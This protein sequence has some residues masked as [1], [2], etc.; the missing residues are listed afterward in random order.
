M[1]QEKLKLEEPPTP[2]KRKRGLK[3]G[4]HK[5]Q[6]NIINWDGANG[7]LVVGQITSVR[8]NYTLGV[9]LLSK[10]EFKRQTE[11]LMDRTTR[12]SRQDAQRI[13]DVYEQEPD[14][15]K[16]RPAARAVANEIAQQLRANKG[17]GRKGKKK[18]TAPTQ[19]VL[20]PDDKSVIR[21][22]H[23][24]SVENKRR[25]LSALFKDYSSLF[26]IE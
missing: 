22:Y 5:D 8:W 7:D 16:K 20:L 25:V 15:K 24:L 6:Y 2:A 17:L 14:E 3:H 19:L 21:D 9:N 11:D 13:I 1:T 12:C 23:R 18:D 26:G 4:L 10:K